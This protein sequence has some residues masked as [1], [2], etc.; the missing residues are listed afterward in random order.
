ML[1]MAFKLTQLAERHWRAGNG[2]AQLVEVI[3]K[4]N[5]ICG[6]SLPPGCP[7]RDA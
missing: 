7:R 4:I 3:Q 6:C 1:T 2:Y 5:F